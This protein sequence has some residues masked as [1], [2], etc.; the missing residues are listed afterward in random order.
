MDPI[1]PSLATSP[2]RIAWHIGDVLSLVIG[3]DVS[4]RGPAALDALRSH[5]LGRE[6]DPEE[7]EVA[8][9]VVQFWLRILF[10]T[11]AHFSG[12]DR[13]SR[14][15]LSAWLARR[16]SEFGE[17]LVVPPMPAQEVAARLDRGEADDTSA[18]ES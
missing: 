5:V 8:T 15:L 3:Y 1:Q 6:P 9:E 11:M 14:E 4:L 12:D 10:P 13:P 2:G 16:A 7:E 18:P 17:Y